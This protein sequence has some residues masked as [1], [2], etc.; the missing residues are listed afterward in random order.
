MREIK[1][2]ITDADRAASARFQ[3]LW[4]LKQPDLAMTQ[5]QAAAKIEVSQSMFSQMLEAK[6]AIPLK[7]ALRLAIL[8]DVHLSDI[9][10][11]F[12][13]LIDRATRRSPAD[14]I[15]LDLLRG[16]DGTIRLEDVADLRAALSRKRGAS[17]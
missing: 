17:G 3:K 1:R 10:P 7:A 8:F 13:E 14:Q 4:A 16:E 9:R 5:E 15:A 6:T 2:K 12:A 11:E